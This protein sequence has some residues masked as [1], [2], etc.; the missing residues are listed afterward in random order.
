MERKKKK[1]KHKMCSVPQVK[2]SVFQ[3]SLSLG[4]VPICK[5]HFFFSESYFLPTFSHV[6]LCLSVEISITLITAVLCVQKIDGANDRESGIHGAEPAEL[7]NLNILLCG[8][9]FVLCHLK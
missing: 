4:T 6:V 5:G 7:W 1:N 3:A 9:H 2:E 8:I